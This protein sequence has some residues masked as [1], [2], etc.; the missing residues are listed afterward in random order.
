M[1]RGTFTLVVLRQ[2]AA[3]GWSFAQ[4]SSA[5]A[6]QRCRPTA[7]AANGGRIEASPASGVAIGR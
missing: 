1:R 2:Q 4:G 3:A 6:V 7:I 5:R